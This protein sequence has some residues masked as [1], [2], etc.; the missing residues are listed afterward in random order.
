MQGKP[1]NWALAVAEALRRFAAED[2]RD[3]EVLFFGN[4]NDRVRFSFP[5]GKAPFE[6][7]MAFL[8][9]RSDGGTQFD[10]VLTEALKKASTAFDGEGKGK[11]DIVFIT[12][13]MASLSDSW[14]KDFNAEKERTGVRMYSIYIGGARDMTRDRGPASL[15]GRISDAVIP[16]SELRPESART[17][18]EHV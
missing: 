7:I 11:A 17:V 2:D 12:D 18:F 14:I 13:G 16:V 5:K 4:N 10:G 6:K 1:A 9:T 15:L 8:G 3:L